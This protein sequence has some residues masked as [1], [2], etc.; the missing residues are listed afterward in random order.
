MDHP[1][2]R[3]TS[4]TIVSRFVLDIW[5]DDGT[6]R[7]ID[8][9]P[10]LHG[11]LYGPLRE[12]TTF[13]RVEIDPEAHTLVWPNGADFDPATL[14]DWP[15]AGP[16]MTALAR[17]WGD[18]EVRG[19][20]AVGEARSCRQIIGIDCATK[21]AKTGLARAA[22]DNRELRICAV[23]LGRH[24]PAPQIVTEWLENAE[25]AT[26]LAIDAPLGWPKPLSPRLA[27]HTAGAGMDAS[28]DQLFCR[29][30]DK[31]IAD[32]TRRKPLEVGADRI[33]RTARAALGLLSWI[34]GEI[35]AAIPLAWNPSDLSEHAVIEV[36]PAT[37]LMA[38]DILA[39]PEGYKK[40]DERARSR[41]REMVE[42]L[43]REMHIP[44]RLVAD[45]S[46]NA[47]MLDA[48]VCVLAGADFLAGRAMPPPDRQH[49]R[50]AEHEGW[51]WTAPC[52][53]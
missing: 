46:E 35:G 10:I 26:L 42:K 39:S 4:F 36:Y 23:K 6:R 50:L 18:A 30:T 44:E 40:S 9:Q 7:R 25:G 31:F 43:K 47:D 32:K 13:E 20:S 33:A 24:Q 41:R 29:S 52:R 38:H 14:R 48:V 27:S 45:L 2:C 1:L 37:T 51:I 5:F 21:G 19:G 28:A 12:I 17:S 15:A 3:I 8:F 53:N 34:R 22:V 11:E 49:R 16:R